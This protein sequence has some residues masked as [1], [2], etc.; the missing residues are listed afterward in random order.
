M[1]TESIAHAHDDIAARKLAEAT[2][3]RRLARWLRH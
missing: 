1:L 3:G 2:V